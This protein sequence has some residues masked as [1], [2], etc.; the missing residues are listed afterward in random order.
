MPIFARLLASL[1]ASVLIVCLFASSAQAGAWPRKQ[2]EGFASVSVRLGWPQDMGTWTSVDPTEDYSTLYF[3]YGATDKVT[4]GL[5]IGHS[6]AGSGKTIVFVQYPLRNADTGTRISGQFGVGSIAG[7]RVIRPGLSVG[8]GLKKGWMSLDSVVEA[9]VDTGTADVKL[10]MTWGRNL[11]KDRKLIVQLQTGKPDGRDP[12]ARIAPSLVVPL[13]GPFKV[14]TG[15]TWGLTG[16]TS[17]GLKFGL[18]TEF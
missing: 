7:A 17:M 18:W 12:F 6:V 4:V 5:D 8:W 13:R 16:D 1:L 3:E 14:E 9:Y 11:G 10:D 2:G 15:V